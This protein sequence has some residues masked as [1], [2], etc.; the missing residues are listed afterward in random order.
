[1]KISIFYDKKTDFR[2]E[3]RESMT[4]ETTRESMTS[5][6]PWRVGGIGPK[7]PLNNTSTFFIIFMI[8]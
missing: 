5:E 7:G 2:P 8:N 4:S 3:T 1:M 6:T